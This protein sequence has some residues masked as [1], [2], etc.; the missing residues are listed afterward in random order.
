M[1]IIPKTITNITI[2]AMTNINAICVFIVKAIIIA[3]N[4]MN[5]LRKN[6]R[7]N[8]FAPL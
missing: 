2:I 6:R 1:N 3:P 5:G 8:I 4:T 7:R